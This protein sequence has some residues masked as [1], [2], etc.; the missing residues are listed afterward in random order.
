MKEVLHKGGVRF[1]GCKAKQILD[2][3]GLHLGHFA[4]QLHALEDAV[5]HLGEARLCSGLI[6][7]GPAHQE[8]IVA[9]PHS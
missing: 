9:S 8:D 3:Y 1:C 5:E 4:I 7:S 6:D 2:R